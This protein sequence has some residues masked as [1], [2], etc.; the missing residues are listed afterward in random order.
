[1]DFLDRLLG[2]DAWT[3]EK[4]LQ[5]ARSLPDAPLDQAFDLGHGT[6]RRT[7]EHI[8]GNMEVWTDLMNAVP[9]CK[10]PDPPEHWRTLDGLH[11]RLSGVAPELAALAHAESAT[12]TPGIASGLTI[13]T[14]HHGS[15]RMAARWPTSSRTRCTTA[16]N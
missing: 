13:W 7:L 9:Q 3:T 5:Q 8:I 14:T 11:E 1:M 15:K 12:R 2:H 4:L 6:V 16:P 10:L